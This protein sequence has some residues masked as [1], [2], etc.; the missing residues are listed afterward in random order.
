[1]SVQ[2]YFLLALALLV[3]GLL[4]CMLSVHAKHAMLVAVFWWI[5]ILSAIMGAVLILAKIIVYIANELSKALG[6]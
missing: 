4:V 2:S 3:G 6:I 1:M 5:G